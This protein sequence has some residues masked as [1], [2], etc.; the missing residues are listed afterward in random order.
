MIGKCKECMYFHNTFTRSECRR[1]PPVTVVTG[2]IR[3]YMWPNT[4]PKYWCGE[5]AANSEG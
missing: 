3:Q 5:F 4:R 1:F 2:D